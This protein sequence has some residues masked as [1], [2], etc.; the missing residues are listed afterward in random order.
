MAYSDESSGKVNERHVTVPQYVL[1]AT[2][3][4]TFGINDANDFINFSNAGAVTATIPTNATVAF[5]LGTIITCFSSGA[6]GLTVAG[7]GGVTLTGTATAATNTTRKIIK[8]AI[9][10]WIAYV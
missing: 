5:P 9:N 2:T 1:D 8:V 3:A 6:A 4:R 10:T 7:A